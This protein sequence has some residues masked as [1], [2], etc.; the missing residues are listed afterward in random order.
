MFG[1]ITST[2]SYLVFVTYNF[3][4]KIPFA[5]PRSTISSSLVRGRSFVE[6]K[7]R[8]YARRVHRSAFNDFEKCNYVDHRGLRT[9]ARSLP[10]CHNFATWVHGTRVFLAKFQEPLPVPDIVED[11]SFSRFSIAVPVDLNIRRCDR[12]TLATMIL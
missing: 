4:I 12:Q 11:R 2:R 3:P 10:I 5:R 8:N 6:S 9:T 7:R 1:D